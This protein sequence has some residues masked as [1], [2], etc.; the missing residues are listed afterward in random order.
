LSREEAKTQERIAKVI[1]KQDSI[2]NTLDERS[3]SKE[4]YKKLKTRLGLI[5]SELYRDDKKHQAKIF[6]PKINTLNQS[7]ATH[8]QE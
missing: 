1:D 6:L 2:L 7:G 5:V 3:L 8:K 4:N